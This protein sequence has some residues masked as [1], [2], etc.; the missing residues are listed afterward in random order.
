MWKTDLLHRVCFFQSH[1]LSGG[2]RRRKEVDPKLIYPIF[3]HIFFFWL[4]QRAKKFLHCGVDRSEMK[5]AEP[6]VERV[7]TSREVCFCGTAHPNRIFAGLCHSRS[8][9]LRFGV[10]NKFSGGRFLF[11]LYVSIKDILGTT[12]FGGNKNNCWD[13]APECP[14][15]LRALTWQSSQ[16]FRSC[17]Y[18]AIVTITGLCKKITFMIYNNDCLCASW[19]ANLVSQNLRYDA[20]KADLS[21]EMSTTE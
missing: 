19:T 10:Q 8:Q 11:L 9:V 18:F 7:G 2:H 15:W 21:R 20:K 14:M 1:F 4:P 16:L 6:D 3:D 13:I 5:V 17:Q 12:N